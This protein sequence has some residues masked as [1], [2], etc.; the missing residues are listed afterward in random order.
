[1]SVAIH[2]P[3]LAAAA[4]L[5]FVGTGLVAWAAHRRPTRASL[6]LAALAGVAGLVAIVAAS[7]SEDAAGAYMGFAGALAVWAWLE[8]A[9]LSGA[10]TGPR[11][12]AQSPGACGLQRFR[13]ASAAVIHHELSL[14]AALLVI[15]MVSW[16]SANPVGLATFALLFGLRLSAKLNIYSGVP[17]FSDGLMPARLRYLRSYF[18]PPRL[19]AALVLS[20]A[21]SFALAAWL[22]ARA[23]E[24]PSAGAALLFALALL[25]AIEHLFLALP[26]R[27]SALWR[28]AAPAGH[29]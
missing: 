25:G 13:E 11:R 15:A 23:L 14:A 20:L 16:D 1:V 9:F 7:G 2:L 4:I 17:N 3:A 18:G 26:V 8:L 22:G 27:D 24:D 12:I 5:W 29:A 21:A 10:V 19:T 6:S 28:W